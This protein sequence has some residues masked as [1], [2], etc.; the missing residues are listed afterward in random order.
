M[1]PRAN[2][3]NTIF[4]CD[5]SGHLVYV[6]IRVRISNIC[7][8]ESYTGMVRGFLIRPA[9][10]PTVSGIVTKSREQCRWLALITVQ[11]SYA[12]VLLVA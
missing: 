2:T 4:G 9:R 5:H 3:G 8:A 11:I 10:T 7:D 1:V 6:L 12:E